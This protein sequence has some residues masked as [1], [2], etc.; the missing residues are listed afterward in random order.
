MGRGLAGLFTVFALFAVTGCGF[1]TVDLS[2]ST[3]SAPPSV[4]KSGAIVTVTLGAQDVQRGGFTVSQPNYH[5]V[6]Y[7]IGNV[8]ETYAR[9]VAGAV[10]QS[11]IF[12]RKP[13][14]ARSATGSMELRLT[15]FSH[16]VFVHS[17]GF[18]APDV[19]DETSARWTLFDGAGRRIKDFD[20][21]GSKAGSG[22]WGTSTIPENAHK[23]GSAAL[24]TLFDRTV[25]G[26]SADADLRR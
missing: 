26:L 13:R 24:Q 16:T 21:I 6:S 9:A 18:V 20:F 12:D 7:Q 8:A 19:T 25:R 22:G 11:P 23:R 4:S 14:S 3:F 15:S 5:G 1:K 17:K 10:F 2:N